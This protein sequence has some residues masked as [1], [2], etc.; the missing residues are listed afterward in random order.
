MP[1]RTVVDLL[2]RQPPSAELPAVLDQDQALIEAVNHHHAGRFVQAETIYQTILEFNP[3]H[4]VATYNLGFLCHMQGRLK[5]ATEAY[6]RAITLKSDYVDAYL[7]LGTVYLQLGRHADAVTLYRQAIAI[8]PGNAMA[9]GNLG[10]ALQDLGELD[11]AIAAY[12]Q[13]LTHQPDNAVANVNLGA[14]LLQRRSWEESIASTRRGIALKPDNAMAYANLGNALLNLGRFEDAL[15]ACRQAMALQ[16]EGAA[17]HATLGGAMLELGA[18]HEAE[19]LCCKAIACD[20]TL[21]DGFFNLSHVLKALNQLPEA[22]NA[23][24]QAIA[25]R[26]DSADY[27]FHLAHLLLLQG[28]LEAGWAEYDWRWKLPDFAW[29]TAIHGTFSQSHWIGEDIGDKTILV[30]T[31]QGLGDIIQFARY[32]PLLAQRANR[33]VVAAHPPVR[34]LLE[35]IKGITLVS[36]ND[37]PLPAFDV[38][39]PLLSLPRAFATRLD[40]IPAAVPYL[41][42]DPIARAHWDQRISGKSLRVG[43]VWAGNPATKRDCFRSPG[44]A[45]LAPL[46]AIPGVEFVVLQVGPGRSDCEAGQ[47]P[48]NVLDLGREIIDLADTAAI[49][50]Q[51]DLMISSCTGPLHL[52][53]ALGV[54]TWAL[55][56]F[57]PYFPWLLDSS[58]TL[59]YPTMRLYRQA[60]PGRDWSD[61]VQRV[62]AD[63]T[64]RV[65][66]GVRQPRLTPSR[67]ESSPAVG[68]VT[69]PYCREAASVGT[70]TVSCDFS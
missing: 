36:I 55:L 13:A 4:A 8:S 63:L 44:L 62:A 54:P 1:A 49:M 12:R 24:H 16:P 67:P 23:A 59:W 11:E 3:A 2:T 30:Y 42:V 64:V 34:R 41:Y 19:V 32:L 39:C 7:N 17:I 27:H 21:P 53:G 15:A 5:D 61:V 51:L 37:V 35:S 50:S 10:K 69:P 14:A 65:Q 66:S 6:S 20:P 47:L 46:F 45:S 48:S 9:L 29:L 56:P 25:L 52:A 58:D 43:I 33:V 28:D 40:S 18:W 68:E 57:A 26:A 22:T 38:H 60:K 70:A 31:E